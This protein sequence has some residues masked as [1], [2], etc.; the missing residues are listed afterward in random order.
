MITG[1]EIDFVV[2]DSPGALEF[3]E[4]IFD[5][6][7]IEVTNFETGLNEAIF[8]LYGV[9]FHMLDENPRYKLFAP[10]EGEPKPMWFNIAVPDIR[11]TY[12]KALELGCKEVQPITDMEAF[13]VSNAIFTDPFG[14]VWTLHQINRVVSFEERSKIW[15]NMKEK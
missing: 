6:H 3:Y 14:Y 9:R 1:S 13:G 11:Q 2:K 5:I 15:E 4:G 10:K 7:R 8:T 12:G